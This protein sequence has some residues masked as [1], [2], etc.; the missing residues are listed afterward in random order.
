MLSGVSKIFL[1]GF[2]VPALVALGGC[3]TMQD[4]AGIPRSGY[5]ANGTYVV[6]E[7]DEKMACRQIK[8][9]LDILSREIKLAP[10]KAAFEQANRPSTLGSALGRA[11]GQPGD[12]LQSTKDFQRA[13]AESDAL[14]ALMIK[15]QCV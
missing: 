2:V 3:A 14:N 9:R 15:K 13:T 5:Q 6:G 7:N 11:F 12:G 4:M 1:G 8:D 10:Q